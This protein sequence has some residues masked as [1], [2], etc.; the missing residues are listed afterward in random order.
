MNPQKSKIVPVVIFLI[1]MFVLA[2]AVT[3]LA[4]YFNPATPSKTSPATTSTATTTASTGTT[5]ALYTLAQVAQHKDAQSCWTTINGNVYD[6]T[7]WINE[8]PGG[9]EAI[10]SICGIDGSAAFNGQHGGQARP[11]NEL[12]GFKIGILN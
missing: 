6:V 2:G 10:L 12:A 7:T 4:N 8:H 5:T 3:V 9:P 11:A 1:I